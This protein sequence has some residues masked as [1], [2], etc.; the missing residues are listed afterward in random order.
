MRSFIFAVGLC[1]IF[2]V[3]G[4]TRVGVEFEKP[5]A[6]PIA[7]EWDNNSSTGVET[8]K[9]WQLFHDKTLNQLVE[10]AY[11][12]NLDLRAAS[13]RI[14]QARAVLGITE[15]YRYPQ[16]QQL[17]AVGAQNYQN[18]HSFTTV[19]GSFDLGWEMDVWGMYARGIESS[20]ASLYAAMASYDDIAVSV[21]AEVARNYIEYKT[22]QERI[23]YA[24]QNIK[25]Q[26]E[27]LEMTQV[28][29][30]A[31]NVSELDMQQAKTQL[32]LTKSALPA[33]EIQ[34]TQNKNALAVLLGT[35]PKQIETLLDDENATKQKTPYVELQNNFHVSASELQ[36]RPDIQAAEFVAHAKSA[37]IGIAEAKLYPHFS[38][39]GT[40]G[41]GVTNQ[42][43]GWSTLS[44][45]VYVQAGPA[46]SWDIFQY[47]R[48]QNEIKLKDAAL[49]E[50]LV[51][52]N[53]KVLEAVRDVS[54]ALSSY[55]Y[56]HT[57][58]EL[59][60]EATDATRRAY[61]LS[62]TQYENGLVGYQRL[63]TSVE[64]LTRSE[65]L[66]VQIKGQMAL[67]VIALYKSLGGGWKVAYDHKKINKEDK[68]NLLK[69]NYW[70]EGELDE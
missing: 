44:D 20:E 29:F 34:K 14:L 39:F 25:I 61:E 70:E 48:I 10:R 4:C 58:Y 37:Q 68:Q 36:R 42:G 21:T 22:A 66:N 69:H 62:S 52:Y 53:K 60:L 49:Q 26:Q 1:F 24:K 63:L 55:R 16:V 64:K 9:W 50:S 51:L 31:G 32:Y 28:Q 30:N 15:G 3:A 17:S 7:T 35:T 43:G 67:N 45:G 11:N 5:Q 40:I 38:L 13:M 6:T 33:L 46:L 47:G 54:N 41:I 2:I 18:S 59:N 23:Y 57:Q 19:G 56:L 27:V 65:D 8:L 12:Q